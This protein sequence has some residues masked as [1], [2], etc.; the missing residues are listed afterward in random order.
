[1]PCPVSRNRKIDTGNSQPQ[2]FP[3]MTTE[4]PAR[5]SSTTTPRFLTRNRSVNAPDHN[6]TAAEAA[7]PTE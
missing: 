3:A 2:G 4:A 6:I 1:M 7:V 5:P